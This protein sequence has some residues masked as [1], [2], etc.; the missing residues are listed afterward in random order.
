M[1]D[2]DITVQKNVSKREKEYM[3]SMRNNGSDSHVN[4]PIV[5]LNNFW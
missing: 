4:N 1:Y 3:R 5:G 2:M